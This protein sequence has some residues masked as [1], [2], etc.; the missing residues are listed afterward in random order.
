VGEGQYI[1]LNDPNGISE[2]DA[3]MKQ[4]ATSQ[5]KVLQDEMA[6]LVVA[7]L[8]AHIRSVTA[9]AAATA[10]AASMFCLLSKSLCQMTVSSILKAGQALQQGSREFFLP[11]L[12][13]HFCAMVTAVPE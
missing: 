13:V 2:L 11:L 1:S 5:L 3:Q 4:M 10:T 6:S 9:A 7:H 12:L 8:W